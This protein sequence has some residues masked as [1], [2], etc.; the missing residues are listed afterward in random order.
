M[1]SVKEFNN[2]VESKVNQYIKVLKEKGNNNIGY[3]TKGNRLS[4]FYKHANILKITPERAAL[5]LAIKH[6]ISVVEMVNNIDGDIVF[7]EEYADE[8]I[9]DL[10]NYMLFIRALIHERNNQIE[11]TKKNMQKLGEQTGKL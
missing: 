4:Y 7:S 6:F 2:F 3:Q 9:G 11:F 5:D 1:M 10:I 8:K